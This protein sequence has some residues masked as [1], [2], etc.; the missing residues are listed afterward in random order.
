[1]DIDQFIVD[2][3][4][5]W[6]RLDTLVSQARRRRPM[7][8]NDLDEMLA[9]YQGTSADL[10]VARTR[11]DDIALSNRLSRTLGAAQGVIYRTRGRPG[12]VGVRFFAETIPAATWRCRR[13]IGLAAALVLVPAFAMGVYLLATGKVDDARLDA[14]THALVNQNQFRDYYSSAP[15]EQWAFQLFTHNIE[16]AVIAF[17]GAIATGVLGAVQLVHFGLSTGTTGA[18]MHAHGRGSEFWGLIL[19]HGLTELTAV[20]V[21]TGA[22]FKVFWAMV[23][24]GDLSRGAVAEEGTRTITV[25]V[26]S[27]VMFVFAGFTEAFV[28]PSSLPTAAGPHRGG[29]V[30]G[31]DDVAVR[32]RP[33]AGGARHHREDRRTVPRRRR[34]AARQRSPVDFTLR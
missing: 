26:G 15:A 14:M 22:G 8:A 31:H 28:T 18:I 1:M 9:L 13:A 2:R 29:V 34:S 27:M 32:A 23:N 19:P 12:D 21:A 16:V 3:Q 6:K 5:R 17:G 25:L 4:E 30:G 20:F 11:F 24:P 10:S 33:F 7:P